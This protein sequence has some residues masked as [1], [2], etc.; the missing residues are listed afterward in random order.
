[1]DNVP[2]YPPLINKHTFYIDI[3]NILYKYKKIPPVIIKFMDNQLNGISVQMVIFYY[4]KYG[5]QYLMT[6]YRISP[7]MV[8][9]IGSIA[10]IYEPIEHKYSERCYTMF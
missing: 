1:M 10:H 2:L 8:N 5:E 3:L 9:V 7:Y 4:L 6:V